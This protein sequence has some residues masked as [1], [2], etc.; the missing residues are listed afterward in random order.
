MTQKLTDIG[1]VVFDAYGTL[2]DVAAAARHCAAEL[3]DD[4]PR[5][6]EVWRDK[7]VQYTWLRTAMGRFEDFWHV[8]GSALDYAL[9]AIGRDDPGLRA[10]LMELYL[11]LAPFPEAR[12]TLE[13]L[14]G[15]GL[16]TGILSNGSVTMLTAAVK[17]AGLKDALDA[18]LSVD[19]LGIYKPRPEVY[20]LA[21]DRFGKDPGDIAF[22]SSNAWDVA[23]AAVFGF[24]TVWVNRGGGRLEELP[25]RPV[26][27]IA[28][29]AALPDLI[30]PTV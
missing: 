4:W 9:A 2:F 13:T 8:T 3:G 12:G 21:C 25:G 10:R 20:Q 5:L 22:L 16:R 28:D 6:A 30:E 26:A 7:Q 14:R 27:E 18:V 23:G 29:L 24:K 15:R 17:N 1:A 19:K 11:H